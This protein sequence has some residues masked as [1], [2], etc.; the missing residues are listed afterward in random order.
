MTYTITVMLGQLVKVVAIVVVDDAEDDV[1]P[2]LLYYP[3]FGPGILQRLFSGI[4]YGTTVEGNGLFLPVQY[5]IISLDAQSSVALVYVR[6]RGDH[7]LLGKLTNCRK[8]LYSV[9][10]ELLVSITNHNTA[11]KRRSTYTAWRRPMSLLPKLII[12]ILFY[13]I[14]TRAH[15]LR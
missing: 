2:V 6:E 10:V 7:K 5:M 8:L 3:V 12:S 15:G 4:M 9:S 11:M 14:V 13:V 1:V